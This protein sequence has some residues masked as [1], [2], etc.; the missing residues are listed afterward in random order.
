MIVCTLTVHF[1]LQPIMA[2]LREAAGP[3]GVMAGDAK[4]QFGILHGVSS[5]FYLIESLLA[6]WLIVRVSVGKGS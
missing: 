2:G 4:T 6:S 1:G 3:G 5:V